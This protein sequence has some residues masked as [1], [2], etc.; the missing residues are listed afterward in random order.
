MCGG[1]R[2][3]L[4]K[5]LLE[6]VDSQ[7]VQEIHTNTSETKQRRDSS[8]GRAA[9]SERRGQKVRTYCEKT[10]LHLSVHGCDHAGPERAT[11]DAGSD[12][13]TGTTTFDAGTGTGAEH[14]SEQP[15]QSK[16]APGCANQGSEFER[17]FEQQQE[18]QSK[19]EE[20]DGRQSER[21]L[22]ANP[23][24]VKFG[25]PG[26]PGRRRPF[27]RVTLSAR[28]PLHVE[29]PRPRLSLAQNVEEVIMKKFIFVSLLTAT[30]MFAQKAE[31]SDSSTTTK[32][33][34][35]DHGRKVK[36][37]STT[38]NSTADSNGNAS[39]DTTTT[40]TKAKKHHGKVKATTT[41]ESTSSD[42]HPN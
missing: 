28:R 34:T 13:T 10:D 39:S 19:E 24:A 7:K 12:T 38:T 15:Q 32:T 42:K 17:Q 40:T 5:W 36:T 9:S 23:E 4:E 11:S 35:S 41:T 25:P 20:W 33:E 18:P 27:I 16:F 14:R 6:N 21:T 26:P 29:E 30:A 3:L 1:A 2:W 31:Q 22:R 8:K 37:D